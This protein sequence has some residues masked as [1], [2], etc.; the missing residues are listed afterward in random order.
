MLRELYERRDWFISTETGQS[1]IEQRRIPQKQLEVHGSIIT[2]HYKRDYFVHLTAH[3]LLREPWHQEISLANTLTRA[4]KMQIKQTKMHAEE[5]L[6]PLLSRINMRI[7]VKTGNEIKNCGKPLVTCQAAPS[8]PH[9]SS[10]SLKPGASNH[11]PP[12]H[13]H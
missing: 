2:Q 5:W 3:K 11:D 9:E 10:H 8:D 1:H 7:C 4:E 12:H 6:T 13:I